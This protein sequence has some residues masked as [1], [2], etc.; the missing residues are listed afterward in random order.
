MKKGERKHVPADDDEN[1]DLRNIIN[2]QREMV[3]GKPDDGKAS[4]VFDYGHQSVEKSEKVEEKRTGLKGFFGGAFAH[5]DRV[6]A[7]PSRDEGRSEGDNYGAKVKDSEKRD[8][9]NRHGTDTPA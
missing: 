1:D 3:G 6:D 2:K 8:V 9:G 5:L 7:Q 4:L